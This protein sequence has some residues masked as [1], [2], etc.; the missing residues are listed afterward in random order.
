MSLSKMIS[1]ILER[2]CQSELRVKVVKSIKEIQA[3]TEN[4]GSNK[5]NQDGE[6]A[7]PKLSPR[8][9]N[10]RMTEKVKKTVDSFV[11][12]LEGRPK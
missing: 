5:N 2:L 6:K 4:L 10:I 12:L 8:T 3:F 9:K 11:N 1:F 7:K